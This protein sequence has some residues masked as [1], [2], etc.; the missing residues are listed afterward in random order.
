MGITIKTNLDAIAA[1]S[2]PHTLPAEPDASLQ[3]LAAGLSVNPSPSTPQ[4]PPSDSVGDDDFRFSIF[5][6]R[7]SIEDISIVNRQSSIDNPQGD[8]RCFCVEKPSFPA[9]AP[10]DLPSDAVECPEGSCCIGGQNRLAS[11]AEIAH[12]HAAQQAAGLT[13][14]ESV[15]RLIL[16]GL[17]I[18]D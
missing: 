7:F 13:R 1:F 17:S 11:M 6:F 14:S 3:R 5:D 10:K 9:D 15:Q 16:S 8:S 4:E 2:G 12:L 18:F